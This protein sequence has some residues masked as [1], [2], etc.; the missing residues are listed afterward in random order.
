MIYA[1][2]ALVVLSFLGAA[3]LAYRNL[4]RHKE[5]ARQAEQESK[6]NANAQRVKNDIATDSDYRERVRREFDKS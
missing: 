6:A 3:A 2:A 4:G 5:R 1:F